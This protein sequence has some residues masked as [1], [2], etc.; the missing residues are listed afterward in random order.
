MPWR[1]I[2]LYFLMTCVG[3][4]IFV[5]RGILGQY[6][7]TIPEDELI[8]VRLG[9]H[10]LPKAERPFGEDFYVYVEEV[11]KMLEASATV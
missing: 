4:E 2:L 8:I 1:G 11:Y 9:H 7:I 10:R 5:M 3:K 6:V